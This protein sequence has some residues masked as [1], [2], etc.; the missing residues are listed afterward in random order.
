MANGS[1]MWLPGTIQLRI[2]GDPLFAITSSTL[3]FDVALPLRGR[4]VSAWQFEV[5]RT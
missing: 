1:S 5:P 4:N 2:T 3:F